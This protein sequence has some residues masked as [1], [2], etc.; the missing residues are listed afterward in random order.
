M[1]GATGKTTNISQWFLPLEDQDA[2]RRVRGVLEKMRAMA[3]H[4]FGCHAKVILWKV[5]AGFTLGTAVDCGSCY[6]GWAQDVAEQCP[7]EA[8]REGLVLWIPAPMPGTIGRAHVDQRMAMGRILTRYKLLTG[9]IYEHGRVR[10]S[11]KREMERSVFGGGALLAGLIHAHE[12]LTGERMPHGFVR[13]DTFHPTTGHSL[14]LGGMYDGKLRA[15]WV[16]RPYSYT[17]DNTAAFLV[18]H[19]D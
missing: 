16:P 4:G 17:A 3:D 14:L 5:E 1:E 9:P 18:R 13:T 10:E 15:V 12:K 2:P 8:T 7:N 11:L 19:E 6:E